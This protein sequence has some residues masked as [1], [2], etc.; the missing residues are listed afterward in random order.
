MRRIISAVLLSALI[1]TSA[2]SCGS[3]D[4][5]H[6]NKV[7]S[8]SDSSAKYAEWLSERVGDSLGE[9]LVCDAD[10]ASEYGIELDGFRSDGY[11]IKKIAD[12]TV[13]CA[14]SDDGFDRAVRYLAKNGAECTNYVYGESPKVGRILIA[15]TDISEYS[16][17]LPQSYPDG[18]YP[19]AAQNAAEVLRS[20]IFEAC[21]VDVSIAEVPGEHNIRLVIDD[22]AKYGDEGIGYAVADGDIVIT[23]GLTRGIVYAA[24]DFLERCL[25]YRFISRG[26]DYLY[27]AETISI[28]EGFTYEKTDIPFAWRDSYTYID[29]KVG[30][31]PAAPYASEYS[32]DRIARKLNALWGQKWIQSPEYGY[33]FGPDAN[34]SAYRLIP[35]VPDLQAPCYTDPDVFD[36]CIENLRKYID[37]LIAS[38]L[39]P[40]VN[41]PQISISAN[42]T[43]EWCQCRNCSK[44]ISKYGSLSATLIDFINR[45]S[46]ELTPEYP[47]IEFWTLAY[48]PTEQA[49]KNMQIA[50]NLYICF[51][52]Y[53]ACNNHSVDA[54]ECPPQTPG[55]KN[56][57]H[58]PNLEDWQK[59]TDNIHIWYYA[60]NFTQ[61]LAPV[62]IIREM[63]RDVRFFADLNPKGI[64]IQNEDTTL[65]FDDMTSY[66][67]A[68]LIWDPYMS[69][70]EYDALI[71]EFLMIFYG[72][73]AV[74]GIYDYIMMLEE[75]GD[76][77]NNCWSSLSG[78][79]FEIYDY[80]YL[81]D[82]FDWSCK[83]FEEAIANA[84]T[85]AAERRL[86]ILSCHMY[87][88]GIAATF[89]DRYKNGTAEEKAETERRYHLLYD[90]MKKYEDDLMLAI[91]TD[92]TIPE[93][94]DTTKSPLYWYVNNPRWDERW[95]SRT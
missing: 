9:V 28:D 56:S 24:Y 10:N 81:A 90:R 52:Y 64:F 41:L 43:T 44:L 22:G 68:K 13:V 17:V 55:F 57:D 60:N 61:T 73:D 35:S 3:V 15:G 66:L 75:A 88:N 63:R 19:E 50:D 85:A 36:E 18:A 21:G 29:A 31:Y 23:G 89:K 27:D 58:L 2:V 86:E 25:G 95:E 39:T 92:E 48:L 33:G 67:F 38:G 54:T 45:I 71:R 84:D 7:S 65:G 14:K 1:V 8:T 78:A 91:F 79:P 32:E 11:V 82:N 69:E 53:L 59:L 70:E 87:F 16:I 49:P 4:S 20:Y 5:P 47:G 76:S 93:T 37:K 51:C 62:P 40:G 80:A 12:Q 6:L 26:V 34:H 46:E 83:V 72:E 30:M 77:T 42:D 94:L 74:D